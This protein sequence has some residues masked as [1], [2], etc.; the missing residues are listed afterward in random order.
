[1][2]LRAT[3]RRAQL[4]PALLAVTAS[5]MVNGFAGAVPANAANAVP[6]SQLVSKLKW[7]SIGPFI[8]GRVL[9]VSGVQQKP[10]V[11]Y[12]G[13]VDGGVWKSIDYGASWHNISDKTLRSSSISIGA[14]E[15]APL[16][17][18]IIYVGTGEADA[19]ND[20]VTGNGM[21][22]STDAGKTWTYI[23]LKDTH[24]ISAIQVDPKNPNI[25]YVSSL[26]HLF[27]PSSQ[28]A[29]FKT[30]NG[31]QTWKKVLFVDN[32]TGATDISMDPKDPSVLYAAMWQVHRTPWKLTSGGPGSG[33]YKTTDSGAHWTN[34]S[35][36]PGLPTG[37]LGRIGVAVAPSD[38]NVVY[39]IVQAK[40]GGLF[41]SNDA[42]KTWARV[43]ANHEL[44]QR[45]FYFTSVYVDP[46]N[47]NTVYMPQV[48]ALWVS[49][50]GG[51]KI[52][53]L[54]TPHGDNHI[55]WINPDNPQILLEGNDGGATVSVNGG[56]TWS[57]VHNQP[58]GQFYHVNL[59]NRFPFHVYGAQQDE[60]AF[61]GPSSTSLGYIPEAAWKREAGSEATWVV[62]QPNAPWINY[63]SFY[64]NTMLRLNRKNDVKRDV[65]PWPDYRSAMA[66]DEMKY[67]MAWT[68]PIMF[69]PANPNE[70]LVGSQYVLESDDHGITWKRISPDLTRNEKSME[71]PTGGPVQIDES[72]AEVFP[73]VSA[74]AVSATN[75]SVIWAGSSDGL[76]HVTT[77]AGKTWANI[78][79]P[80][81]AK[82]A[83]WVKSIAV[84]PTSPGTAYMAASRYMWDDFK[85]YV[86]ETTDY[87]K[88]WTEVTQ[89]ILPSDYIM[90]IAI[91]ANAPKVMFLGARSN[92]YFSVN[93]GQRWHR[94]TENLPRAQVRGVAIQAAQGSVVVATHGRGFWALDDLGFFED[95]AKGRDVG[96]QTAHLFAP[97][98]T[99]LTTAYGIR[100]AFFG[101]PIAGTNHAFGARVFF[102]I[103]KNYQSGTRVAL[104]FTTASGKVIREF[105]L[106]LRAAKSVHTRLPADEAVRTTALTDA[107]LTVT[108]MEKAKAKATSFAPGMNTFL[109]NMRYPG[110]T[111]I[112]PKFWYS[113][114]EATNG[115]DPGR[116]GPE[117]VPGT[118]D[119]ILKYG[120]KTFR[121]PFTV[122]LDPRLHTTREQ[123]VERQELLT[124]I[125][126]SLD[127][128]AV[129][130]NPAFVLEGKATGSQLSNVRAAIGKLV[131]VNMHSSEGDLSQDPA[132]QDQMAALFTSVDQAYVA[133]R[134]SEEQVY[135]VLN[136]KI[137]T[138]I[139]NLKSV[140]R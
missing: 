30:T 114:A 63:G 67:R 28:G 120:S 12:M 117:I 79:P 3:T 48:S 85:P 24:M 14:I 6:M 133:P 136:K 94:V 62:P 66:S 53:Q 106:H 124:K 61:E 126:K 81:F 101:L 4:L 32:K 46:K 112:N 15:V 97:Q 51:K 27:A 1:M 84:S 93:G 47:A 16:N 26:G 21:Y 138:D 8:G 49:Y 41:R 96:T 131:Q 86:F 25:A 37:T 73:Y 78:T 39:A 18:N 135:Q 55:V 139:A 23:G 83:A 38:P 110:S 5:L 33:L 19:R 7:R 100:K 54:H 71:G 127:S 35:K 92:V 109:W 134:P 99:Y 45:G 59:D 57:P 128:I 9:A 75:G 102:Y 58:T 69:S 140:M 31:G 20:V 40:H 56:R 50:D 115:Y 74:L 119:V 72:A 65:A 43:N 113:P 137:Q 36:A 76:V 17:P 98:E 64:F 60:G 52:G 82:E 13:T 91:D 10:N 121:E 116:R 105:P 104:E 125:T 80:Q 103:P 68:H 132:L 70:L 87:G 95:L 34:I 22:K 89:G 2:N 118:F 29:V 88:H 108:K 123:L 129:A 42:G 77:N 44:R 130:V 11:F 111:E 107:Q 122:K 90:S